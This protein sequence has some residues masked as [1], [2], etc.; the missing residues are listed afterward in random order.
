MAPP[1]ASVFCPS[2]L[3]FPPMAGAYRRRAAKGPTRG[4]MCERRRRRSKGDVRRLQAATA[5]VVRRRRRHVGWHLHTPPWTRRLPAALGVHSPLPL[6]A[7]LCLCL[8]VS[9]PSSSVRQETVTT[10][11]LLR[12]SRGEH[13]WAPMTTGDALRNHRD[14]AARSVIWAL[15]RRRCAAFMPDGVGNAQPPLFAVAART[16]VWGLGT[17]LGWDWA[18]TGLGLDWGLPPNRAYCAA[19]SV[20]TVRRMLLLHGNQPDSRQ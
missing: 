10:Q 16:A 3:S 17:G 12:G 8:C 1:H 11:A 4:C 14:R 19:A 7:R 15:C 18:G 2:V 5:D 13:G 6:L 9:A 20:Q